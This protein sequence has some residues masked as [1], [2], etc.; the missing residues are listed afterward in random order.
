MF[1]IMNA[2]W[3]LDFWHSEEIQILYVGLC[4]T[5]FGN[6]C[7]TPRR[8]RADCRAEETVGVAIARLF[9]QVFDSLE[10]LYI[11]GEDKHLQRLVRLTDLLR[12]PPEQTLGEVMTVAPPT[13]YLN[14]D[15][16]DVASLAVQQGL[17][18]IPVIDR[19]GCLLGVVPSQTLLAILRREHIEDLHRLAEIQHANSHA[20]RALETP[21]VRCARDR[22]PWLLVGLRGS[23]L[24]TFAVSRF[25]RVLEE[26][27]FISFFVPGIVYLADVIGTQTE[28]IV[29]SAGFVFWTRFF[30]DDAK[31]EF[32]T[33]CLIGL[34]LGG[35]SLP[36]VWVAFG[37]FRLAIAVSLAWRF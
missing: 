25:E 32:W 35:A 30:A 4:I 17:A 10:T 24:A 34:A 31:G 9:G 3:I 8:S 5:A 18:S 2:Y 28:A 21:P 26:Q 11:V 14:D 20:R 23:I 7:S 15:Q 13:V 37:D 27:V 36:M 6:G 22:L 29:R 19:Q 16:E 1:K 33:G 12:L